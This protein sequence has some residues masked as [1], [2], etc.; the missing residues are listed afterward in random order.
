M[1][2]VNWYVKVLKD[3]FNFE[4]RAGRAEFWYFMLGQIIISVVLRFVDAVI[5]MALLSGL[6]SLAT[7]L[8]A[9]GV[10][11]RRLHDTDRSGWM[12]LLCLIPLVGWLIVLI[13]E[14]QAGTDGE[15]RF[16]EPGPAVPSGSLPQE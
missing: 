16:G 13:F 8:P 4:G 3:Y 10:T 1:A 15:N 7:F 11:V 14:I 12:F 5:G 2:L 6:F 9:L